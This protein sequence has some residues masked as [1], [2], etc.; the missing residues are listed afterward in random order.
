MWRYLPPIIIVIVQAVLLAL[1]LAHVIFWRWWWV[2]S[3]LWVTLAVM[4]AFFF[5]G[6]V[7]LEI[8]AKRGD[9]A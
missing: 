4:A 6:I 2:L 5:W 9:D 7:M 8:W 1:R 3:P